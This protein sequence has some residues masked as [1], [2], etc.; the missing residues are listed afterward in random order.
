MSKTFLVWFKVWALVSNLKMP[1]K[2][3]K[4][5][6]S[7]NHCFF[8]FFFKFFFNFI[9]LPSTS[10]TSSEPSKSPVQA[11]SL[12]PATTRPT[13]FPST[14]PSMQYVDLKNKTWSTSWNKNRKTQKVVG[15]VLPQHKKWLENNV[16]F[17]F[18]QGEIVGMELAKK[19]KQP[20]HVLKFNFGII[21]SF[22]TRDPLECCFESKK[23]QSENK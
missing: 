2:R 9:K 18:L 11:P 4:T 6:M 17:K 8:A 23:H 13:D 10:P 3:Y 7:E 12:S 19:K 20:Q 21:I 15:N 5:M 22:L 1:K 16:K 14:S